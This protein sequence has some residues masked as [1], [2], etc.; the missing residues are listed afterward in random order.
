MRVHIQDV[1]RLKTLQASTEIRHDGIYRLEYIV[2]FLLLSANKKS[3]SMRPVGA[4]DDS[5]DQT[6]KLL[7]SWFRI[8]KLFIRFWF[9]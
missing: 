6:L 8:E 5:V 3:I 7:P 1:L 2:T 9:K 4:W